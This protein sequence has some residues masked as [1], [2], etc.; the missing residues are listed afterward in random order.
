[1]TAT[2][3]KTATCTCPTCETTWVRNLDGSWW[4]DPDWGRRGYDSWHRDPTEGRRSF[5]P[6]CAG[7]TATAADY[8]RYITQEELQKD[9]LAWVLENND[10]AVTCFRALLATDPEWLDQRMQE[11]VQEKHEDEF[12]EWRC[13]G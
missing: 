12:V 10:D 9:F 7:D 1:M 8:L 6:V 11:F 2:A 3:R 4:C 13:G 5:C